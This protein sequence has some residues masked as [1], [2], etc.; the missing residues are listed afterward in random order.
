MRSLPR[1]SPV[2]RTDSGLSFWLRG[3]CTWSRLR[4]LHG[5]RI[6]VDAPRGLDACHS[7]L[8]EPPLGGLTVP[9]QLTG[10]PVSAVEGLRTCI[11]WGE[12]KPLEGFSLNK[13]THWGHRRCKPCRSR[14]DWQR[15]HPG[16]DYE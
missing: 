7:L 5:R 13:G 16:E 6:V 15:K 11:D 8:G 4:A 12:T 10:Y 9:N 14:R 3:G 1:A 2:F